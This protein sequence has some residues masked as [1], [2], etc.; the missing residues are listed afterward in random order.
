MTAMAI[1]S[2][3]TRYATCLARQDVSGAAACVSVPSAVF[4]GEYV[5]V[6]N[7][8]EDVATLM[9][10]YL[11]AL[12]ENQL[13]RIEMT[14]K[15]QSMSAQDH[16]TVWVGSRFSQSGGPAEAHAMSRYFCKRDSFGDYK[17]N[18]FEV[19]EHDDALLP[20]PAIWA[21]RSRAQVSTLPA[22][23]ERRT[24]P[25]GTNEDARSRTDYASFTAI[26]DPQLRDSWAKLVTAKLKSGRSTA[27]APNDI[28]ADLMRVY[29]EED[30]ISLRSAVGLYAFLGGFQA[31]LAIAGA[32]ESS[33]E[34]DTISS[35]Q[36]HDVLL[37]G[38]WIWSDESG[39]RF[40]LADVS[41]IFENNKKTHR[42]SVISFTNIDPAMRPSLNGAAAQPLRRGV[43]PRKLAPVRDPY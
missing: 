36:N 31:R 26:D 13:D 39:D 4:F 33:T 11:Q 8:Q 17:I 7:S 22:I 29:I 14:I 3:I 32:V 2:L 21:G 9:R 34:F 18:M 37:H 10:D 35:N 38:K 6:L 43:E 25:R 42:I 40:H 16:C 28:F 24:R 23:A 12:G 19:L 27:Q 15:A 41:Y 1:K 30:S 5:N 20:D